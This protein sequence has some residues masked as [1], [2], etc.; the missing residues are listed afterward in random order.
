MN[1][2]VEPRTEMELALLR[3]QLDAALAQGVDLIGRRIF[4][5]GDVSEDSTA[6][7][8]RGL[9]LMGDINPAKPVDLYITSYGGSIDEAFALH[10]VTRTVK[11]PVHTVALGKCMSA[12]PL[13]VACGE[14]G[15]RF[16]TESTSF[17]FHNVTLI[18]EDYYSASP[19]QMATYVSAVQDQTARYAKLLTKYTKKNTRF[20]K[21][22]LS[23]AVD[24]YVTAEQAVEWG[25][26][27]DIWAEKP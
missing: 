16:T 22:V 25:I 21:R 26:V 17:M 15:Q 1:E 18:F 19:E 7:A 11:C 24:I 5:H 8:I 12:A 27:D 23:S 20:W 13:L 14:K 9:Y 10:D 6:L 2:Q 3:G 4:L